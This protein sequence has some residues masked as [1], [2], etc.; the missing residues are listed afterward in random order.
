MDEQND[1]V[2]V[3]IEVP[4]NGGDYEVIP[5]GVYPARLIGLKVVDKPEWKLKGEEGEDKQ[6]FAWRFEVT[7][8]DCAGVVLT[9]YT[10]RSWHPKANAHKHAAA[11][12]GVPEI[13]PEVAVSTKALAGRPCQLW[14]IEKEIKGAQR[15][16]IDK[17]TPAPKPRMKP[18][19]TAGRP[20]V[21]RVQVPG[22]PEDLPEEID[23]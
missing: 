9:D 21:P 17:V 16:F 1:F 19:Q 8:G 10:N 23:F 12:L 2:D 14:V 11:L 15:N 20:T 5:E 3:A 18:Q 22:L 13:T 6:Q 7:Q 4:Q